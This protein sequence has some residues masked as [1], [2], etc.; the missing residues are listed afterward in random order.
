M[1]VLVST[2]YIH[3]VIDRF[4]PQFEQHGIELVI[5][6]VDERLEEDELLQ[7][8]DEIDGVIAGDDRFTE[9]VLEQ[10]TPRLKA[11]SKWGTGIDS[12]DRVACERLG[13]AVFNTP[14]A[15]T[16]PVADTVL[17]YMLAF[18][19]T[20]PWVDR[21]MKAGKWQKAGRGSTLRENSLGII[22]VGNIGQAVAQRAAAFGMTL[23]G[24][25]PKMPS[26]EFLSQTGTQ[27]VDKE[28]LL[29]FCD[30]ISLNCD[31]NPTS[32]HLISTAEFAQMKPNAVII[33]T[34]RGPVIDEAALIDALK[35]QSI[36]GAA[37]DVFEHEPLPID[38]PLRQMD[39]V[40]LSPHDSNRS[41]QCWEHVH[42]NTVQQLID[43]LLTHKDA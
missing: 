23:Y 33:N 32:H 13:V 15:F 8:V 7:W 34:A 14:N 31:L 26:E 22:G 42:Q 38:S 25:D 1:R 29:R 27:M 19:R 43:H 35:Q 39:T 24:N 6:P 36:A 5:P 2:P 40:L 41:P 11:I 28:T 9:Q 17:G 4:R 10:A 21:N 30:F 16:D 12:I 37:L 3:P 18:A 20:I